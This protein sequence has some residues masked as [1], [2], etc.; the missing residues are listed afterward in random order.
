MDDLVAWHGESWESPLW[1]VF[2]R[3]ARPNPT[4]SAWRVRAQAREHT[5]ATAPTFV[6]TVDGGGIVFDTGTVTVPSS[7]EE[8]DTDS[9]QLVLTPADW[10]DKPRDWHGFLDVEISRGPEDAPAE[11]RTIVRNRPFHVEPD[12]AR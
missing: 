4:L 1:F 7:G 6:W 11:V 8:L 10:A 3:G 12:T 9:I 5:E 2:L